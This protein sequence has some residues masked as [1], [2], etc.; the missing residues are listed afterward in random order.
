MNYDK[1]KRLECNDES[2]T[3]CLPFCCEKVFEKSHQAY[4]ND[5]HRERRYKKISCIGKQVN[6]DKEKPI[7]QLGKNSKPLSSCI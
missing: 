2:A 5:Q 6:F 1:G 4:K 7:T 3:L